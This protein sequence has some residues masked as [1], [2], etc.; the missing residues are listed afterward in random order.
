[1][2]KHH[3][4]VRH[5]RP[6]ASRR[7]RTRIIVALTAAAIVL[8]VWTMARRS[9]RDGP[10]PAHAAA[11]PPAAVLGGKIQFTDVAAQSRQFIRYASTIRLTAEQE[12]VKRDVL[13][14]MPAACC[15]NSNAH[16]CCCP[17]NLSKTVWG[18][19]NYALT[20]YAATADDLRQI[21]KGWYDFTNPNGYS[22]DICYS[23][24][25]SRPFHENGC[26]GMKESHLAL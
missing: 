21:L 15:R 16:T 2:S 10:G 5:E 6:H 11:A 24:G 12:A 25:C 13:E 20:E 7:P 4:T 1:M 19:S 14:H 18:L 23:G 8:I 26:G 3:R 22:G 9:D 17:C